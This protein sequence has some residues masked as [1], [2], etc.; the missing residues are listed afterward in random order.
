M[1]FLYVISIAFHRCANGFE[2]SNGTPGSVYEAV[3]YPPSLLNLFMLC[4]WTSR[5]LEERG[6]RSPLRADFGKTYGFA[7]INAR[8][9]WVENCDLT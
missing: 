6:K 4:A 2:D 9:R 1:L 8:A 7:T 5:P 3:A